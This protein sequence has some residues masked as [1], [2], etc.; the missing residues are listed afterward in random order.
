MHNRERL[1]LT[2]ASVICLSL[3]AFAQQLAPGGAPSPDE[4]AL[5]AL[6]VKYFEVYAKK[7]LDAI[8]ALWSKD[9]PGGDA[10]RL[11]LHGRFAD[12]DYQ[13]SEPVISRIRIE[14]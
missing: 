6:V 5:R 2:F 7:D 9:A 3:S 11:R 14:G 1:L 13:F 4:V 8:M 12:E 10:R